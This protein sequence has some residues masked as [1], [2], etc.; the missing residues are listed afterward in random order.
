M[1]FL[2]VLI[3]PCLEK[4]DI[5]GFFRSGNFETGLNLGSNNFLTAAFHYQDMKILILGSE[6]FVGRNLVSGLRGTHQVITADMV[7][8]NHNEDY[9]QFNIM[10][11][12]SVDRTVK[13]ADVVINLVAH[14]LVSSF[15]E[16]I[17][18]AK[19]N[20]IGLLNVLEACKKNNIKK[21]IFTSASS[22]I[23]EPREF[24][25]S[26]KHDVTPKTAYGI[27]KMASEHYLRLYREMHGITYVIFRFFNI[28][29]PH[30]R[31]GLI[32]SL[33]SRITTNQPVTIFGKGD[34]VRDYVYIGDIVPF[35][36]KAVSTSAGDNMTF[37]MGTGKGATIME[38]LDHFS[39]ILKTAPAIDFKPVRPGEIGNFV[40]DTT[41]LKSR[42]GSL[43]ETG[44]EKGLENTIQWLKNNKI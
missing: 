15:T 24:R 16:V 38:V 9:R 44:I 22:I 27:T 17:E 6:G 25:V 41:L 36:E 14:T 21:V 3:K 26:E 8:G 29:G 13:D 35:F 20:I 10:D 5:C 28:Y 30:Q 37:N 2:Y 32:P 4:L 31:N 11:Y 43:P 1:R 39:K 34:Q 12:D 18:N 19:T 23:G 33:Y 7:E 42:F 40:A